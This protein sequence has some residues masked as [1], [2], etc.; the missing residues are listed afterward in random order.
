MLL[1]SVFYVLRLNGNSAIGC[2]IGFLSVALLLEAGIVDGNSNF[3]SGDFS[4]LDV[5]SFLI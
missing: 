2:P 5:V 4:T 1:I 3:D